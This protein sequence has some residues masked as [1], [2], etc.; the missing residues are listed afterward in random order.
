MKRKKSVSTDLPHHFSL[1]YD[2]IWL[3]KTY[4][5]H[6]LVYCTSCHLWVSICMF[7]A[8]VLVSLPLIA[9]IYIYIYIYNW[10]TSPRETVFS[11]PCVELCVRV[12]DHLWSRTIF[13]EFLCKLLVGTNRFPFFLGT[14]PVRACTPSSCECIVCVNCPYHPDPGLPVGRTVGTCFYNPNMNERRKK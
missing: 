10:L 9:T 3:D 1:G 12:C 13:L 6:H 14:L 2:V 4:S 11:F 7:R 8:V 5:K